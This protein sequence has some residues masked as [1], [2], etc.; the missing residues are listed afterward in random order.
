MPDSNQLTADRREECKL[1]GLVSIEESE[2][3]LL[4][5][6]TVIAEMNSVIALSAVAKQRQRAVRVYPGATTGNGDNQGYKRWAILPA[7]KCGGGL[8]LAQAQTL[9]GAL[10]FS[11]ATTRRDNYTPAFLLYLAD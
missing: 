10:E 8:V 6:H 5:K 1:C 4:A 2:S 11:R 3:I 7:W 9:R